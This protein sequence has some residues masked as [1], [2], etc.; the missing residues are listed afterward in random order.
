MD[1][2]EKYITFAD[3]DMLAEISGR[4][5]AHA[6][7]REIWRGTGDTGADNILEKVERNRAHYH[8]N[9]YTLLMI[10]AFPIL[11]FNP[12]N[13]YIGFS[14]IIPLHE[15]GRVRYCNGD[16]ED[17]FLGPDFICEKGEKL[18]ALLLFSLAV[19]T[20]SLRKA[21]RGMPKQITTSGQFKYQVGLTLLRSLA[22]H[23][24]RM[25]K[26]Y[27]KIGT[28][29]QLLAQN[30]GAKDVINVLTVLGFQQTHNLSGDHFPIWSTTCKI[31]PSRTKAHSLPPP[32][33]QKQN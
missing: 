14:H 23:L 27:D 30:D 8:K 5:N 24:R 18:A 11:G 7:R 20:E 26:L 15:Q 10:R 17:N 12:A 3:S 2:I 22:Y 31:L 28:P 32:A 13:E 21:Y 4:M 29:V 19:D 16:I 9:P 33:A 1:G 25:M 6:F